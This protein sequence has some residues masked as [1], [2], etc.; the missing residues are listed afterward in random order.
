L[1]LV[2]FDLALED[3]RALARSLTDIA[4]RVFGAPDQQRDLFTVQFAAYRAEDVAVGGTLAHDGKGTE[5][6][7]SPLY[8]LDIHHAG[9]SRR[10]KKQLARECTDA[11][12][13]Q[14]GVE[15]ESQRLKIRVRFA[16]GDRKDFAIA[17]LWLSTFL[18]NS[19]QTK[20][21]AV[22]DE[23]AAIASSGAGEPDEEPAG[24]HAG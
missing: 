24:S 6:G 7:K 20:A 21:A 17:G 14:L 10:E 23:P 19:G 3:K 2:S 5:D 11:I 8:L 13:R 22:R 12:A 1:K 18:K 9:A 15:S 4:M 16:E